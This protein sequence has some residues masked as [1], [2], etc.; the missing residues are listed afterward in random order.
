MTVP[1]RGHHEFGDTWLRITGR[2]GLLE[3]RMN[4]PTS[5]AVRVLPESLVPDEQLTKDALDERQDEAPEHGEP[6]QLRRRRQVGDA[7]TAGSVVY[8]G[9]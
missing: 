4:F 1:I 5:Q 8:D 3:S 6:K 7:Q 2:M 9:T